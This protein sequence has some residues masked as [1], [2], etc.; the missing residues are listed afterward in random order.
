MRLWSRRLCAGR[1]ERRSAVLG[2][3]I[4][5]VIQSAGDTV[6]MPRTIADPVTIALRAVTVLDLLSIPGANNAATAVM[7]AIV[8]RTERESK[9][10]ATDTLL[11]M[12]IVGVRDA[13]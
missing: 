13:V 5:T 11:L 2:M 8:V 3:E 1:R 12:M 7:I 9:F 4:R 6:M 10:V